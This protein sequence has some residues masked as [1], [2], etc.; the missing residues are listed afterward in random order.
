MSTSLYSCIQGDGTEGED[1][2]GFTEGDAE[3]ETN[4]ESNIDSTTECREQTLSRRSTAQGTLARVAVEAG[5][6]RRG[7][8]KRPSMRNRCVKSR[9]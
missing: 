2:G 4:D 5:A 9:C 7:R 8:H 3:D 6:A 1:T